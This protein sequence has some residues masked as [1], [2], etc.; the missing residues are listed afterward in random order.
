MKNYKIVL[1]LVLLNASTINAQSYLGF[2]S[3][4]Y[5][6]VNSVVINPANIVDSRLK[7]D[8]N[9]LGVSSF[10][11]TDYL[12]LDMTNILNGYDFDYDNEK[13]YPTENNNAFLNIDVLGPSFMFNI[14]KNNSIAIFSRA[15]AFINVN[16]LNGELIDEVGSFDSTLDK[17]VNI[18]EG[19][20]NIN[21]HA[22][23]EFGFTYA[24][25]ILNEKENFLKAGL[26]LKHLRGAGQAFVNG[27]SLV[28]D[29][30]AD[31]TILPAGFGTTGSLTSSGKIIYGRFEDYSKDGYEYEM[32]ESSGF[33]TDLGV[34]YEWRPGNNSNSKTE[35]N[36]RFNRKDKN[37][38]KLKLGLSIT[39]IGSIDYRDGL[40]ETFN[41]AN[42]NLSEQ[43]LRDANDIDDILNNLYSLNETK[44]SYRAILPTALHLNADWSFNNKF[45]LNLRSDLSLISKSKIKSSRIH[46]TLSLTPRYESKWLSFYLPLSVTEYME[47]EV[48][49]LGAGLRAGPLYIGSGSILSVLNSKNT[50][51]VDVYAGLKIPVYHEKPDKD[52]DGIINKLDKCPKVPGPVENNGCPWE[53]SDGDTLFDNIDECPQIAGS[54]E[55]NGCPWG[56]KDGDSLLDNIDKCPKM[57]GPI[58]NEGCPWEDSDGDGV[59]DKDD[60]C[61][62]EVGKLSNNGCPVNELSLEVK[63]TF[64]TKTILFSIGKSSIEEEFNAVL[65]EIA[66]VI[67]EYPIAKFLIEGHTDSTGKSSVNQKIS[68]SRAISVKNFLVKNNVDPNRLS[69]IG[70]GESKPVSIDDSVEGRTENRRVEIN[71]IN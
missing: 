24:R 58:E 36:D 25:V 37:Q 14:D 17:D 19:D 8:I 67:K 68:E 47:G 69:V 21:A 29:Y 71:L 50:Q 63:E 13:K 40:E 26:T 51:Q 7:T 61:V 18:N 56:D 22:W 46:S 59:L 27:K 62:N 30:D 57:E 52:E 39:D 48:L 4:N 11:T 31:G 10:A 12:K 44:N 42:S 35:I 1:L 43:D 32:P 2:L 16:E 49:R 41:V 65:I 54:V 38:Y 45:Y 55:N 28:V 33:G 3:D 34:I 5:S 23:S 15:R 9:L 60:I 6:G 70:Y 66:N 53:D 20:F 64:Y